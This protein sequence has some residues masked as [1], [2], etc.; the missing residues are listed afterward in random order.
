MSRL[1]NMPNRKSLLLPKL[2]AKLLKPRQRMLIH[3]KSQLH[4][5]KPLLLTKSAQHPVKLLFHQLNQETN[6]PTPD[7][8]KKKNQLLEAFKLKS[9]PPNSSKKSSRKL[10]PRRRVVLKTSNRLLIFPT[11]AV[12]PK[13]SRLCWWLSSRCR[14]CLQRN[15]RKWLKVI[16]KPLLLPQQKKL[17]LQ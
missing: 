1:R 16:S 10:S 2:K 17:P 11:K 5:P 7:W 6:Q 14:T 15:F 9:L 12:I 4:P 8:L 3:L 13:S